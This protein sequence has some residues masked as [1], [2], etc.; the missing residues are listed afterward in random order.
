MCRQSYNCQNYQS[1]CDEFSYSSYCFREGENRKNGINAFWQVG[2]LIFTV[3]NGEELLK[4]SKTGFFVRGVE[5]PQD[6][7]EALNVYNGFRDLIDGN[8]Q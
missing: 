3:N 1:S 8:R 2:D 5:V 4:V 7:N 6:E